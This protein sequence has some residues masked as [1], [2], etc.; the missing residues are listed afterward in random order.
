MVLIRWD[1]L[2]L[3]FVQVFFVFK[4]WLNFC[5]LKN[6]SQTIVAGLVKILFLGFQK[7]LKHYEPEF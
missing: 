3:V 2:C 6:I 4:E 7:I 5:F 1:R